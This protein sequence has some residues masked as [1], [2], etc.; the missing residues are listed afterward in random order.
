MKKSS[1]FLLLL[2]HSH[3]L[4]AR[5]AVGGGFAD[6]GINGQWFNNANF[7]GK[8]AFER[9]DVRIDFDW[10]TDLKPG[11]SLG[12]GLEKLATDNFSVIWQGVL[13]P[14]YTEEY[15]FYFT[16]DDGVQM[17]IKPKGGQW[18]T[19]MDALDKIGEH[20]AKFAMQR[21]KK[22]DIEIRY[23]EKSGPAKAILEWSGKSFSREV[24]DPVIQLSLNHTYKEMLFTDAIRCGRSNWQEVEIDQNGWPKGDGEFIF[25]E[26]LTP[27]HPEPLEIGIMELSFKSKADVSTNGNCKLVKDSVKYD[28]ETKTTTALI[29]GFDRGSNV[30]TIRIKNAIRPDGSPGVTDVKLMRPL[31]KGSDKSFERSTIFHPVAK[32]AYQKFT[33]IRF[34]RVHDQAQEW[35]QRTPPDFPYQQSGTTLPF[36][37]N[38]EYG[39]GRWNLKGHSNMSHEYEI[40]LCNTLGSDYYISTPHLA[41]LDYIKKLAQLIKYGSDAKG[42]PYTKTVKNPVHPPLNP[43]LRVYLELSNELWNFA[44][45]ATYAAYFDLQEEIMD[46]YNKKDPDFKLLNF[47]CIAEKEG[48][49]NS[50]KLK[51][52]YPLTQRWWTFKTAKYSDEFRKVFGDDA[53]PGTS[54]CPR[55]RPLFGWQYNNSN[56]T[57]TTPLGFLEQVLNNSKYVKTP[58][59]PNYYLYCGG[60]AGYYSAKNKFGNIVGLPRDGD[61]EQPKVKTFEKAPKLPGWEFKD[62]AGIC[63]QGMNMPKVQFGEQAVYLKGKGAAV[64]FK[65][66]APESQQSPYYGVNYRAVLP[67]GT[68]WTWEDGK[69]L[70]VIVNGKDIT[71]NKGRGTQPLA[72][73]PHSQWNRVAWWVGSWYFTDEFQLA[74][75]ETATVTFESQT[76]KCPVFIDKVT[77]SSL[78]AFYASEIPSGGAA[79]GQAVVGGRSHGETIMGD[80]RWAATFGLEYMTY[81]HGWS[82][83]GDAGDTPIQTR[84]KYFDKRAANSV[85][86]AIDIFTRAG[87]FNPT[88][89]TYATWPTYH[90]PMRIEGVLNI[91]DWPLVQ[92]M[93]T[94]ANTLPEDPSNG[95][96]IPGA[97]FGKKWNA[98]L[99]PWGTRWDDLKPG[100]W[101][102]YNFVSTKPQKVKVAVLLNG[103]GKVKIS[104]NGC[105]PVIAEG[106]A[107][108]T[109]KAVGNM[110]YGVNTIRITAL[111]GKVA[112]AKIIC[113]TAEMSDEEMMKI[114]AKYR[115]AGPPPQPLKVI[116]ASDDFGKNPGPLV[117]YEGGKCWSKGPWSI[118]NNDAGLPGYEVR[119]EKPLTPN[120]SGYAI[121]GRTYLS[122]SRTPD[123]SKVP[124]E[125]VITEGQNSAFGIPGAT[126]WTSFRIRLEKKPEKVMVGWSKNPVAANQNAY[127]AIVTVKDRNWQLAVRNNNNEYIYADTGIPAEPAK[128]YVMAMK[129]IFSQYG[130]QIA[131]KVNGETKA[132]L[133]TDGEIICNSFVFYPGQSHDSASIDD[134]TISDYQ[135]E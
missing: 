101:L 4:F 27:Y 99:N 20:T 39:G 117:K 77:M 12:D 121:G 85:V 93:N 64:S 128:V 36:V 25:S 87:G 131:L 6:R 88:F 33:G 112:V 62:D 40:M 126:L 69:S 29:E 49:D 22:Y 133:E 44:Q 59:P 134:V 96:T 1:L 53:M 79:M 94:I 67:E 63:R 124:S 100:Q 7:A 13:I 109:L 95:T 106:S 135:V 123:F 47:D 119:T 57:C 74:P 118:Q 37:Y 14:R 103:G 19:L 113:A 30:A 66:T 48:K 89:G 116:F 102:S 10:G 98:V 68:K 9:R 5:D 91:E 83:G 38:K 108:G 82:A 92:G 2:L 16:D 127:M 80:G 61:F 73:T 72:W 23:V 129:I 50:G 18:T 70:K 81:E 41:S 35:N 76:D 56:S 84:A 24:I 52:R 34:Q 45:V 71:Y 86:K 28:P 58:H 111:D 8:P 114:K 51:A 26:I 122:C 31:A 46:M 3:Q 110:K 32:N 115:V 65:F 15:T 125:L 43:N 21:G 107:N 97:V 75:G 54:K 17:K 104:L 105:D 55:I 130:A 11:G 78:D 60:G 132:E 42:N 120:G 90:E